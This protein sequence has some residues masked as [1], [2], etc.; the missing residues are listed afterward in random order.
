MPP[1]MWPPLPPKRDGIDEV[2]GLIHAT[3][4]A[5]MLEGTDGG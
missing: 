5:Q 3:A 4:A 2:L 1:G